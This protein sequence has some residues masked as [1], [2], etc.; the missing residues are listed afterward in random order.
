M[1][2]NKILIGGL[3]GGVTSFLLGWIIYGVILK[4]AMASPITGLMKPET[5]MIWWAMIGSCL[6]Q[7]LLLSYVFGK[8]ANITTLVGGATAGATLGVLIALSYDLGF[9]AMSN[10][11]T[12]QSMLMD[13]AMSTVMNAAVGAVVGWWLGRGAE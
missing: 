11:F 5:D 1:K 7:G 6:A 4:D 10:M 8:W 12:M 2:S 3:I 9:Y 13:V